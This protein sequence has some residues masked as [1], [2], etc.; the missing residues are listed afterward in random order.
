MRSLILLLTLFL[1]AACESP[2]ARAKNAGQANELLAQVET[3]ALPGVEG[4]FDHF[5]ADL[6]SNRLFVAALGNGSVEVIDIATHKVTGR[7]AELPTPQGVAIAPDLN[8]LA[9]TND[10]DGSCRLFDASTLKPVASIDLKDDADNVRYDAAARLFWVGYGSGGLAAI[11]PDKNQQVA[12]IKLDGHPESFQLERHG[13][14]IFVN[15]PSAKQIAVID[16]QARKL[17][18]TWPVAGASANFPM[19]LDENHHRLFIGCRKPAR[20]L[21]LDTE[22]GKPVASADIVEDTDDLFYDGTNGRIYV[23]GGGGAISIIAQDAPDTYK[24]LGNV[25]TAPGAR[26][27]YFIPDTGRL[28]LAVPHRGTQQSEIRIFQAAGHFHR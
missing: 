6:K 19:A 28:Y 23:S 26:T 21:V 24:V 16:R 3:I 7:I 11:D 5:A 15:V 2:A 9:V 18:T 14:R 17:L 8:R 1:V 12:D 22:S 25:P 27:C 20:L 4:R 10:K 13:T